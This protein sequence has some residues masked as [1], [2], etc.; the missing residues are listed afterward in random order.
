MATSRHGRSPTPALLVGLVITLTTV[1]AYSAYITRQIGGLRALQ[2]DVTDR[3]RRGA[4]QLLRAQNDLNQIGLAMRDM[5]DAQ[6]PYPVTAWEAQFERIHADLDDALTQQATLTLEGRTP[7]QA[8]H[9]ASALT[10]FW[11]ATDRMFAVARGGHDAQARDQVRDSLQARQAALTTAVARLLVQSSETEDQTGQRVRAIYSQVQRQVYLFL[12]AT[13]AAIA[14]TSLYLMRSNRRL[15]GQLAELSDTRR[16]LAQDLIAARESTLREISRELHD[17]CGQL[18]TAMGSMLGRAAKHAPEGSELRSD[19]R[20]AA[21]IAQTTLDGVRGL[22]QMLHPSILDELG[23]ASTIEWYLETVER[24]RGIA[25]VYN[26][27]QT[28]LRVPEPVA[29]HVYRIVQEAV[30]NAARHS[31]ADRIWIR[32]AVDG[33]DLT[34]EVE[35]HGTGL[36]PPPLARGL[37][38][39]AMRERAALLGGTLEFLCPAEGGTLLRLRISLGAPKAA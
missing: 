29:I 24:Q 31:G 27:P 5:L 38:L 9:L 18:L 8:Q 15:F 35:D 1:V 23:L 14:A 33:D 34:L 25:V 16:E 7:E 6:G 10:Q 20:T 28:P 39:V 36:V 32:L 11:D 37:G 19:I 2:N 13:L 22:S 26:G 12:A 21:E 4:V 17:E 30:N 3:N